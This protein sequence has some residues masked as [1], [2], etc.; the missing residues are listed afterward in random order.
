MENQIVLS[1]F[2]FTKEFPK[3][4]CKPSLFKFIDMLDTAKYPI[5]FIR[6][7]SLSSA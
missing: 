1:P 4:D 5:F 2:G 6:K 3:T 7:R